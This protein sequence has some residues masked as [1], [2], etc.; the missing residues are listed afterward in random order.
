MKPLSDVGR[1]VDSAASFQS[2]ASS[3][4][5]YHVPGRPAF[6]GFDFAQLGLR[7][8]LIGATLQWVTCFDLDGL[9]F[10]DSDLVPLDFLREIRLALLAVRPELALISQSYD[11]LHHL[12]ACDLTYEG[13]VRELIRQIA[14]GEAE[15]LALQRYWEEATY[16]FPRG[17]LRMRWLE[18]K[19]QGRAWR[20]YGRAPRGGGLAA[21]G[22]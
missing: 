11:E 14:R 9:R 19:E 10:D 7:R 18:E 8:Y 4:V 2:D 13:G 5:T 21:A 22:P 15:P 17:A 12:G 16:S 1:P 3:R 6:A 20:Y